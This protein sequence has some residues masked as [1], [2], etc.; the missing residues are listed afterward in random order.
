LECNASVPIFMA[1]GTSD[2]IVPIARGVASRDALSAAGHKVEWHEY[3][4]PHS[5]SEPEIRDIA[6]FLQRV[7]P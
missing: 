4:M 6:V 5:V 2:P 1:H 7:L 3:P